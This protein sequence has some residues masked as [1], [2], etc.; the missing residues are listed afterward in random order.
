MRVLLAWLCLCCGL[1]AQQPMA[2][3]VGVV[4][5]AEGQ[6]VRDAEVVVYRAEGRGFTCLDLELRNSWRPLAKT[7]VDKSGRFGLQL[8]RGLVL[9]VD[10][11]HP[12]H[13]IW[14]RDE[15]VPGDELRIELAPPCTFR[16]RLVVAGSGAGVAGE[17]RAWDEKQTELF[18]GRT[19]PQ[20]NFAFERLPAGAFTC[21]IAPDE[22]MSPEWFQGVLQ[23][24][25]AL[26]QE[27][28]CSP[29]VVL[30]GTVT[31]FST[32]KP[33]AGARVGEGWTLHKAVVSAADGTYTM[34]GHGEPGRSTRLVCQARGFV[35][36]TFDRERPPTTAVTVDFT[37]ERGVDVTGTIVDSDGKPCEGVYAAVIGVQ[38]NQI[39]WLPARTDAVGRFVCEGF[40]HR[41]LG[42][43]LL[44]RDGFATSVF[45]LP[46]PD[47]QGVVD[48]GTLKLA[49]PQVVSGVVLDGRGNPVAGAI[50]SLRGTNEDLENFA[51]TPPTWGLLALYLG[52]RYAR[53]DASGTFAFGDVAP[54]LYTLA[55]DRMVKATS[56]QV[57][58]DVAAGKDVTGVRL[59]RYE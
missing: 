43:L 42:V 1:S 38:S 5:D 48:L 50:V 56:G 11:D 7:K 28:V 57:E 54:G 47:A 18:Q 8:P 29:G 46:R 45:A 2:P 44:R 9:R 51:A 32:G 17:L 40:D 53:T 24:G 55:F 36:A 49:P 6:A 59:W 10:V 16:G 15:L 13:A 14:R 30:T 22:A 20:G 19:D 12:G 33:I 3:L 34:R 21:D 41:C 37:L 25:M 27:F 26:E 23:P 52:D 4:V 58:I 39:P 35:P 31:E